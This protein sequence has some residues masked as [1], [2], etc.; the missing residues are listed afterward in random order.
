[1]TR[2]SLLALLVFAAPVRAD[3]GPTVEFALKDG[4]VNLRLHAGTTPV[5]DAKLIVFVGDGV[6]AEGETDEK[7][8]GTFPR[9]AAAN[10]QVVFQ[11]TTG[12]SAPIPLTFSGDTIT[13]AS[14]PVG[15]VRPPCCLVAGPGTVAPAPAPDPLARS[16]WIVF[17]VVLAA[18]GAVAVVAYRVTMTR[19]APP[20]GE[21]A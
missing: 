15:G 13:P 11:Y 16:K 4:W 19:I 17:G 21:S 12:S 1:V 18:L 2:L 5:T 9:P 14:A 6:W 8:N 10:C 20:N 3:D 7:G